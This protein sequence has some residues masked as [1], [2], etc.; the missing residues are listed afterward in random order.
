MD[1]MD[2]CCGTVSGCRSIGSEFRR[3]KEERRGDV[4]G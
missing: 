4:G 3:D 2:C 1:S